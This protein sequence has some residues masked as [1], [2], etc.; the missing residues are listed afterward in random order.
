LNTTEK[1]PGGVTG[2]GFLKGRSGNPGGRPKGLASLVR[3]ATENGSKLVTLMQRI[4]SGSRFKLTTVTMDGQVREV[5]RR[6]SIRDR[7]DAAQ[8]L[9]DRGWGRVKDVLQVE[10]DEVRA[11]IAM[12]FMQPVRDP[13]APDAPQKARPLPALPSPHDE[14]GF[15]M[16]DFEEPKK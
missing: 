16:G 3:E 2:K 1:L 6:P 8:W 12:V 15:E 9:S 11:P 13:L 4:A 10:T 7:M 14:V 5:R